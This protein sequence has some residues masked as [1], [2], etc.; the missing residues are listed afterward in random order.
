MLTY[1]VSRHFALFPRRLSSGRTV[2]LRTYF[3]VHRYQSHFGDFLVARE[4]FASRT[5]SAANSFKEYLE[6]SQ[7][8]TKEGV[9]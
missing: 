8:V 9:A 4:E 1:F 6:Q 5:E 3:A 7:L 2:W